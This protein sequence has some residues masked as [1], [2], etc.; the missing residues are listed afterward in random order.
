MKTLRR[1]DFLATYYEFLNALPYIGRK[2]LPAEICFEWQ[3]NAFTIHCAALADVMDP[4]GTGSLAGHPVVCHPLLG[5]GVYQ[6]N[7]FVRKP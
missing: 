3:M 7:L 5:D 6:L 1:K 2:V 4:D